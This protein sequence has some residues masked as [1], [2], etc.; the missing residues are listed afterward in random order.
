MKYILVL[1]ICL[2]PA[3]AFPSAVFERA[4]SEWFS[5]TTVP[6]T[7]EP[8]VFACWA[9]LN[10][11]TADHMLMSLQ[12]KDSASI[13]GASLQA[14]G[15][16][17]NDPIRALSA[18]APAT[19]T[20]FAPNVWFHAAGYWKSATHWV[21]YLNG[22]AGGTQPGPTGINPAVDRLGIGGHADST[23]SSF[24]DGKLA[25]CVAYDTTGISDADVATLI[26]NL[27]AGRNPLAVQNAA[28]VAYW[29]LLADLNDAKGTNNLTANGT[30]SF[31]GG[32][33]P[34]VDG[35]PAS[36]GVMRRRAAI[37]WQ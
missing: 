13:I 31:D 16:V 9:K 29:P 34:T 22:V 4:N 24:T 18:T 17:A 33:N 12:D 3:K 8:F 20:D 10:D 1:L 19:K 5:T 25:H 32:D 6:F 15:S 2:I 28:L 26:T 23:P 35:P 7:A 37:I 14:S 27:A 36:G 21:A 11:E 30:I